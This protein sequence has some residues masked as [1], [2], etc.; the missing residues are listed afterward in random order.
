MLILLNSLE[1][2]ISHLTKLLASTGW[3]IINRT[4]QASLYI[5]TVVAAPIPGFEF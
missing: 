3:Y 5:E 1:R 4:G 2:T